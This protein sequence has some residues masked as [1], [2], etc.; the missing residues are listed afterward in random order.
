MPALCHTRYK[1]MAREMNTLD[2]KEKLYTQKWNIVWMSKVMKALR[3]YC[4]CKLTI[5]PASFLNLDWEHETTRSRRKS[6]VS[7]I[8]TENTKLLDQG[9]NQYC[10]PQSRRQKL[11]VHIHSSFPIKYHRE[12]VNMG[13]H[14]CYTSSSVL[15]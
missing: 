7:R 3:F 1:D 15:L 12:S 6:L 4:N 9:E 10:S 8:L 13:P 5:Y 11:S 2:K 14:R